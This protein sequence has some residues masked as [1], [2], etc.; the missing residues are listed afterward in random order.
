MKGNAYP[1]SRLAEESD[2]KCGVPMK[3][4]NPSDQKTLKVRLKVGSENL[5]TQKNAEIYSGLGLVVSP[6][7]SLDD[8]PATSDGLRDKVLNG[9]EESPSSILEVNC[10]LNN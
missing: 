3:P 4:I 9:P 1:P 10:G 8:S 7:S 2:S 5:T 6:S